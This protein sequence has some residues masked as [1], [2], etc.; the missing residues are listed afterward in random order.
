M[1]PNMLAVLIN[2]LNSVGI[3]SHKYNAIAET[4]EFKI[5]ISPAKNFKFQR[6]LVLQTNATQHSVSCWLPTNVLV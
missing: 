3:M 2:C 4:I 6:I 1:H 5:R